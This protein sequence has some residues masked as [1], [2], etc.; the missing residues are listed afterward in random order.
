MWDTADL[1]PGIRLLLV[2]QPTKHIEHLKLC[3]PSSIFYLAV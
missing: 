3:R 1:V 2:D